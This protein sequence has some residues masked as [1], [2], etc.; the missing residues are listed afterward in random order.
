MT[1]RPNIID[2]QAAEWLARHDADHQD[3][4]DDAAFAAWIAQDSRHLGAYARAAA[5]LE[6]FERA[7]ALKSAEPAG[8]SVARVPRRKVAGW[9]GAA[10]AALAGT[11]ILPDW[12]VGPRQDAPAIYTAAQS[13]TTVRLQ[14]GSR[15]TLDAGTQV[16]VRL[17]PAVRQ[18]TLVAGSAFFEV[19]PDRAR[20]FTVGAGVAAVTAVGTS[21]SVERHGAMAG[22]VLVQEGKVSVAYGGRAEA[23]S[24]GDLL[25]WPAVPGNELPR[26]QVAEPDL[27][28]RLAWTQGMLAFEGET[29]AEA[30]TR[31]ARYGS[32]RITI[33]DRGL[34][35]RRVTGWFSIENPRG[36]AHAVAASLGA[37]IEESDNGVILR[38]GP[39]KPSGSH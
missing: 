5:V 26:R 39:V 9:I 16:E 13:V 33:A 36:F 38:Q 27:R 21:F 7:R 28:Q 19:A 22:S 18:V 24:A 12:R 29:L 30:V 23:A 32:F 31:F 1:D 14:D 25:R 17:R 10:A 20:P 3:L 15:L 35:R 8:P 6:T 4:R 34:A 37:E 2:A 11:L